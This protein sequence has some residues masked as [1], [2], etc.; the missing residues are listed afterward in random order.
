[1]WKIPAHALLVLFKN[2]I[3]VHC[4]NKE[5]EVPEEVEQNLRASQWKNYFKFRPKF[6]IFSSQ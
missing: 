5:K 2:F 6:L 3:I 4:A 1:M